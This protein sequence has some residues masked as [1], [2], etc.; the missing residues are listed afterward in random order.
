MSGDA[1]QPSPELLAAAALGFALRGPD[2]DLATAFGQHVGLLGGLEF[3]ATEGTSR[4]ALNLL[5][6]VATLRP[7]LFASQQGASIRLLRRVKLSGALTPVYRL[8][9]AV[10]DYAEKLQSVHLDVQTLTAI[11]DEGVWKD[12]VTAHVA[13]V[14]DWREGASAATFLFA[15]ASAV[16]QN[17]LAKRSILGELASLL[18]STKAANVPR[19]QEL[20][21]RLSDRKAIHTL[22]DNTDRLT[23][24]RH[25]EKIT[26]RALQQLE[27]HLDKPCEL[28]RTWLRLMETRPGGEGF[29]ETTVQELRDALSVHAPAAIQSIS[30]LRQTQIAASL[31]NALLCA[32]NAIESLA[33]LFGHGSHSSTDITLRP[34]QVLSDDLLLVTGLRIIEKGAIDESLT[35][36]EALAL[37]INTKSH[38]QTLAEAFDTRL[39]KGDLYGAHAV[40]ERMA[41]EDDAAEDASRDRLD[42]AIAESRVTLHSRLYELAEQLEQAFVIGEVLEDERA[43]VTAAIANATRRLD[44]RDDELT[45]G[46]AVDVIATVVEPPFERGVESVEAQIDAFLPLNDEREQALVQD[47]LQ[48]RDLTTL[49]EQ[50]D[51]LKNNQPLRSPDTIVRSR[52]PSFVKVAGYIDAELN[53]EVGPAHPDLIAA[54]A[55][56][57]DILG[58][59]FSNLSPAEAKRSSA[60][61]ENWFEMTRQRPPAPEVVAGFFDKL[62][63]VLPAVEPR[64]TEVFSLR[65]KPLRAR[66]LCPTHAFGSDADGRYELIFNWNTPANEPIIQAV[67][68]ADPNAHTI[69]LHF[70]KLSR[71]DRDW[72][73]RWSIEHSTQF[74]TIDETLVLYLASVSGG[75]LRALFECS[76]PFTSTRPFFTAPGLVPP[77]AFFGRESERRNVM[78][79][80][81]SCFVYG[82]RQLGKT[83]LLHAAHAAFHAP[84]AG[85]LATYVDLKYQDVGIAY[86]ADHIWQ[87]LWQEFVRLDI[88]SQGHRQ[89][90]GSQ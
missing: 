53:S 78:D 24:G 63:F 13:E 16:W 50:L 17:W 27:T 43:D 49:H 26:G 8:A 9:V 33:N 69:V 57:K 82:G 54:V 66:E 15:A 30:H 32:E 38:A 59:L 2:E 41:A 52:L 87:V 6:L 40:C 60:L 45:V 80:Y 10:A 83:A 70:G 68:N 22:I 21:N 51:C 55:D 65:T 28:A 35:P 81:G 4:D 47:A 64:G 90:A 88:V 29:V 56:R 7:A 37:L 72:L 14:V 25:G 12:R 42:D 5:L 11:L 20:T 44:N 62:G 79:R 73:R 76:L 31:S 34:E 61:L 58:L 1:T 84:D 36:N 77:E 23:V 19:V 39:D 46:L 48:T 89:A 71:G 18:Q 86:D 85:R 67:A 74:I 75:T 3:D